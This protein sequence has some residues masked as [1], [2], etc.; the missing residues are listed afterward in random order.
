MERLWAPWRMTYIKGIDSK[1][2]GCVFCNK[3]KQDNDKENLLLFRGKRCF[4]LMNLFPYNNGHLMIIPYQHCS[5]ILDLDG[6]TSAE[7]WN[8]TALSKKVLSETMRP[9]GFNIGMNLGRGAGA[10]IDQHIHMHIVPRWNG[11]TNFMPVLSETR[12]ISQALEETYGMLQPLFKSMGATF[13]GS[14]S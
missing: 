10:G 14:E 7:L 1:E 2:E 6:E 3:P 4:V 5:D 11:D 9:E 8:L 13:S 12:V